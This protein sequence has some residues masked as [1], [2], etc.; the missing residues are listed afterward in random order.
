MKELLLLAHRLPFPPNKGDKIRSYHLWRFLSERYRVHLGAFV[1]R[2]EDRVFIP[3]VEK[4]CNGASFL[5]WLDGRQAKWRSLQGLLTGQAL[6]L[7]Y[8]RHEAMQ[9]WVNDLLVEREL[10]GVVIYSSAMARFV[11]HNS[12]SLRLLVDF[13]DCDSLKWR[14]YS[15]TRWGLMRWIYAREGE[16][17]LDWEKRVAG[18]A[19]ASFFVSPAE[20]ALFRNQAPGIAERIGFWENGVDAERFDPALNYPDP[21]GPGGK[22]LVFTGAMDYWPNVQG[23]VWFAREVWPRILRQEP[24]TRWAIAG[25]RPTPDVQRLANLPGVRVTGAMADSRPYIAHATVAVAPLFIAQGVQN[26][27][28]EAMALAK[29]VVTT[30]KAMEGIRHCPEA[31]RWITEDPERMAGMVVTLLRDADLCRQSGK[32]GRTCILRDYRWEV[33]LERLLAA[34]EGV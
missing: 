15:T 19:D 24:E 10:A 29:P 11:P 1:D 23:V 21:Y 3:E 18:R 6:T 2:E 31:A 20:A 32:A 8:Y 34:L 30:P 33:N 14:Q 17:L 22:M 25:G 27:V 7:P 5:P 16:Q 12:G 9:K 26:K 28:L 13:V 4:M